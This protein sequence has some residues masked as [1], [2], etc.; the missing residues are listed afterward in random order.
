[1]I[2]TLLSASGEPIFHLQA[3]DASYILSVFH[4]F[5]LHLY[6]GPLISDDDVEDLLVRVSHDSVIPLPGHTEEKWFSCDIAPFE[7]PAFGTGDF[8]PSAIMAKDL[9]AQTGSS[10]SVAVR[11]VSHTILRGKPVLDRFPA[12]HAGESDCDTLILHCADPDSFLHFDLYYTVMS[13]YPAICRRTVIRNGSAD[14]TASLLRA[15][16]ASMDLT[17]VQ[18]QP[19]LL[20]L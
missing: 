5:V 12:V 6:S 11:Y 17:A 9:S 10:P 13:A 15:Y 18:P 20:H 1:M 4:G 19:E 8:R 3:G 14:R 16:S 2:R 7:Y